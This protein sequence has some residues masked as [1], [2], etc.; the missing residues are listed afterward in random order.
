MDTN[1]S[2]PKSKTP[3]VLSVILLLLSISA[4]VVCVF[5]FLK[6]QT[7]QNC[8]NIKTCDLE[9]A[10][11]T[12]TTFE[13]D[14][15]N[16]NSLKTASYQA[17]NF[18]INKITPLNQDIITVN[19][20]VKINGALIAESIRNNDYDPGPNMI[21]ELLLVNKQLNVGTYIETI[22]SSKSISISNHVNYLLTVGTI[23]SDIDINLNIP[24][25]VLDNKTF[26]VKINSQKNDRVFNINV[27]VIYS[28]EF[29]IKLLNNKTQSTVCNTPTCVFKILTFSKLQTNFFDINFNVK[30]Q[31]QKEITVSYIETFVKTNTT[32]VNY[33]DVRPPYEIEDNTNKSFYD[34]NLNS[35]NANIDNNYYF[36]LNDPLFASTKFLNIRTYIGRINNQPEPLILNTKWKIN[37]NIL[38]FANKVLENSKLFIE[39]PLNYTAKIG[40]KGLDNFNC[41]NS[42]GYCEIELMSF[43]PNKS[44]YVSIDITVSTDNVLLINILNT[45]SFD[46]FFLNDKIQINKI[47]GTPVNKTV[48]YVFSNTAYTSV[49]IEAILKYVSVTKSYQMII[50]AKPTELSTIILNTVSYEFIPYNLNF[51]FFG[52]NFVS[53]VYIVVD[54]SI[55]GHLT[56]I[57]L[58]ITTWNQQTYN[59]STNNILMRLKNSTKQLMYIQGSN[60]A[61]IIGST[62]SLDFASQIIAQTKSNCLRARLFLSFISDNTAFSY[63]IE[64]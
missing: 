25:N 50:N 18:N 34:L 32:T 33:L 23:T 29:T 62:I 60:N 12:T 64:N 57:K 13:T 17:E 53:L 51:Q 58:N 9:F 54:N 24:S 45:N 5:A 20:N 16:S 46:N 38:A 8:L 21:N 37:L 44:Y 15:L 22:T 59:I 14:T 35:T 27:N 52:G 63:Q 48:N 55:V 2:K 11:L 61:G 30:N 31:Q 3:I 4:V 40:F 49:Y 39:I 1:K 41:Q 43:Q 19:N 47:E 28:T 42:E 10:K 7:T 26:Y 56:G 36:L 6:E